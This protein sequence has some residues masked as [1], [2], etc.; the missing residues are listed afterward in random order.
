[1]LLSCEVVF[2]LQTFVVVGLL[3]N[4]PRTH[5]AFQ[6]KNSKLCRF[7]EHTSHQPFPPTPPPSRHGPQQWNRT[8]TS[9]VLLKP[10]R[11]FSLYKARTLE[12]RGNKKPILWLRP[13]EYRKQYTGHHYFTNIAFLPFKK[14]EGDCWLCVKRTTLVP[15]TPNIESSVKS[16]L[17]HCSFWYAT[18]LPKTLKSTEMMTALKY[19]I[20]TASIKF[21]CCT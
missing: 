15:P 4:L 5:L 18:H 13:Q 14:V 7:R 6:Q 21:Y 8:F 1:M 17:K 20:Q 11:K 10:D 16:N 3:A 2:T 19:V 12:A 9:H